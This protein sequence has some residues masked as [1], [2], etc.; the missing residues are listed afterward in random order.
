MIISLFLFLPLTNTTAILFGGATGFLWL[1]TVPLTSGTVAQIFGSRYLST[2][3]GIVFFSHQLGAFFG[4][5][6]DGRVY[7]STG[8]YTPIWLAAI[9]L[10]VI[11]AVI[12]LPISDQP[13]AQTIPK[14]VAAQTE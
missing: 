7:D 13:Y 14:R 2:L 9:A 12:H 1:A 3:Y 11:A 8:S 5:W 4:V 6:L 10:G